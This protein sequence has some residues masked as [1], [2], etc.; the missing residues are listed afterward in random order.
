MSTSARGLLAL[1]ALVLYVSGCQPTA[2]VSDNGVVPAT[3]AE[4]QAFWLRAGSLESIPVP[5]YL[6]ISWGDVLWTPPDQEAT[7]RLADGSLLH[8]G[9]DSRMSV[10]AP[11]P[12]DTR[13]IFRLTGGQLGVD[14]QSGSF[15]VESYREVPQSL[16][17]VLINMRLL[18]VGTPAQLDLV[19][20][21]AGVTASV[22]SGMVEALSGDVRGT[23]ES[24]WQAVLTVDQ[25]LRIISPT[26]PTPT[27]SKTPTPSRTATRTRTPT[28]TPTPTATQ[29]AT[30]QIISPTATPPPTEPPENGGQQPTAT[31]LPPPTDTPPPPT[32]TPVPP[33]DPPT[34]E[35]TRPPPT[36]QPTP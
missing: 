14:A 8:L 5:I 15:F 33:T 23:L 1:G 19:F 25:P 22:F 16:R 10:R 20:D 27:A 26:T 12:T 36:P 11:Y 32:D 24:G 9:T 7:L 34:T 29:T 3:L 17:L 18:P 30:V 13:P 4:G 31:P 35:P 21:E 2:S 6:D 28:A